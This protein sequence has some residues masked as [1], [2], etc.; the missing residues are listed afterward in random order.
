MTLRVEP[1]VS[2]ECLVGWG[3]G[4]QAGG[5]RRDP[6]PAPHHTLAGGQGRASVPSL[7]REDHPGALAQSPVACD[8]PLCSGCVRG[9][10]SWMAR[11]MSRPFP[12]LAGAGLKGSLLHPIKLKQ[13]R[14]QGQLRLRLARGNGGQTGLPAQC[15]WPARTQ[16]G[17]A[18]LW[19]GGA[20]PA[21]EA[22]WKADAVEKSQQGPR[23][24]LK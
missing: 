12:L 16:P 3:Q 7:R 18:A 20:W 15:T 4:A 9:R 23:P 6:V 1:S 22:A 21:E 5:G 17:P 10:P 14:I 13:N 24:C 2:P 19:Q 8:S 11:G